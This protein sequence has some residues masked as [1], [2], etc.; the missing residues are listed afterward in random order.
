M[1]HYHGGP[2]WP[3]SAASSVWRNRHAF[4]S[5]ARPE[6][7]GVAAEVASTFSLDNGAFS[8]WR[9]GRQTDWD[10]YYEWVETWHRHP[11][12]DFALIPDV[13]DGDTQVN[14]ELISRWPFGQG[15]GVPVW[16][17]HEPL[18][19]LQSLI[20]MFPR[21]AIGSSGDYA[22]I[23]TPQWWDRMCEAFNTT[24]TDADGRPK[25]KIH[26]LR[27]LNPAIFS[28][29]PFASCDSTNVARN[30]RDSR[31]WATVYNPT[32]NETRGLI[33]AARIEAFNSSSTWTRKYIQV[34]LFKRPAQLSMF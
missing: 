28:V 23:G 26:G 31:R 24:L 17:L 1:I 29:F 6:Q 20:S 33:L 21:I 30:C 4:I 13:I 11:A 5:F 3:E 10:G 8:F 12:F 9:L 34:D 22:V 25:C 19:W 16:H 27:M 18:D 15:I 32:N 7:I 14:A 2:I